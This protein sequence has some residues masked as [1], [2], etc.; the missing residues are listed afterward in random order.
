M[1]TTDLLHSIFEARK[2]GIFTWDDT[3][4]NFVDSDEVTTTTREF[5]KSEPGTKFAINSENHEIS[6]LEDIVKHLFPVLVVIPGGDEFG[7]LTQSHKFFNNIGI[8]NNEMSVMFRLPSETHEMF[9]IFVK[10]SELNSPITEKTKVVFISGKMP[11]PVLK[12]KVKFHCVLN[13]GYNNVHYSL[14]EFVGK[15]EN[16]IFYSK[17]KELRNSTFEFV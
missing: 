7:T 2:F 13:L 14:R 4:N 3:I 15:H 9:N 17:E 5:L 11:K 1:T 12:S 6:V 10:Q 8:A 16:L